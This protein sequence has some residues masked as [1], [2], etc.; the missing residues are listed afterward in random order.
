MGIDH[1][2][3]VNLECTP[4]VEYYISDIIVYHR[5]EKQK[6]SRI[7]K[8]QYGSDRNTLYDTLD[9]TENGRKRKRTTGM[10]IFVSETRT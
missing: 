8:E 6:L 7:L 9:K 5:E 2:T 1:F 10:L 3:Q 4:E